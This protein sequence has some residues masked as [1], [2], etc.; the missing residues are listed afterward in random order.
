VA[1][2]TLSFTHLFEL[3]SVGQFEKKGVLKT[4]RSWPATAISP[5]SDRNQCR[6]SGIG[7][8]GITAWTRRRKATE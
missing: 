8:G 4:C 1:V 6:H 5:T 7:K 3:G 2:K